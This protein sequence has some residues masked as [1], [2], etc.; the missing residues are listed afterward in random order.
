MIEWLKKVFSKILNSD[1]KLHN[2]NLGLVNAN[3]DVKA[4]VRLV[5]KIQD[6][7]LVEVN[8][9]DNSKHLVINNNG[10]SYSDIS[11]FVDDKLNEANSNLMKYLEPRLLPQDYG[12][13]NKDY[14][15]LSTYRDALQI[16][17]KRNDETTDRLLTEII[18]QRI[19]SNDELLNIV[20]NESI[21]TIGKLTKAQIEILYLLA[22]SHHTSLAGDK[23]SILKGIKDTYFSLFNKNLNYDDFD[24][25]AYTGCIDIQNSIIYEFNDIVYN[26]LKNEDLVRDIQ[27]STE[28]KLVKEKWENTPLKHSKL[29]TVG[30][31]IGLNYHKVC[32]NINIAGFDKLFD[33]EEA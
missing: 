27:N 13:L 20:N 1:I 29:T 4:D 7:K 31:N 16:S 22:L 8:N 14:D 28:Y 5:D 23:E 9:N 11:K 19:K 3:A 32:S 2:N 18:E 12:R 24:H 10:M 25:L 6:N 15:F 17:A 26:L 30:K 33:R 21:I